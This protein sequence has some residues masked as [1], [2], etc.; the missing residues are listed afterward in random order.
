[1]TARGADHRS[2]REARR[3]RRGPRRQAEGGVPVLEIC[4]KLGIT[5]TTFYRW[6]KKYHGV[7]SLK[8]RELKLLRDENRK[9]KQLVADL[10]LDKQILQASVGKRF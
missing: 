1:M 8:L 4:R 5:E 2:R 7:S 6:R 10:S 9:L 3:G